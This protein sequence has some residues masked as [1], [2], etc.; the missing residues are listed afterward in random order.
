MLG[1]TLHDGV[2]RYLVIENHGAPTGRFPLRTDN[3]AQVNLAS[4]LQ[5]FKQDLHLTFVC[6]GVQQEV[7][8]NEQSST[9]EVLQSFLVLGIIL[10]LERHQSFQES[11][12][13]VVFLSLIH[14][15]EPTRRS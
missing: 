13:M 7:V 15:S 9:A 10:R 3:G 11:L 12:A 8:Q 2:G 14:I 4:F 6:N 1:C 5:D